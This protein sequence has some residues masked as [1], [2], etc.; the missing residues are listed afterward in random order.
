MS[1]HAFHA[2]A[3][4]TPDCSNA[5]PPLPVEQAVREPLPGSRSSESDSRSCTEI[6]IVRILRRSKC[7]F[8]G[9]ALQDHVEPAEAMAAWNVTASANTRVGG[10]RQRD[11]PGQ[12]TGTRAW[13]GSARARGSWGACCSSTVPGSGQQGRARDALSPDTAAAVLRRRQSVG[14]IRMGPSKLR[15][16]SKS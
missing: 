10:A 2:R 7:R 16:Y 6:G 9:R 1:G 14:Q 3:T 13:G 15:P 4:G 8:C 12:P 11:G 5:Q